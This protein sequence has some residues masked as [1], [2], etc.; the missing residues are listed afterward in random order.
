MEQLYIAI[1]T[2]IYL[3]IAACPNMYGMLEDKED[4]RNVLGCFSDPF[5]VS[6]EDFQRRFGDQLSSILYSFIVTAKNELPADSLGSFIDHNRVKI[7]L[8]TSEVQES[9]S[10]LDLQYLL[11]FLQ[12]NAMELSEYLGMDKSSL[13][14]VTS[15]LLEVRNALAHGLYQTESYENRSD[16]IAKFFRRAI[17]FVKQIILKVESKVY[18]IM[19]VLILNY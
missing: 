16:M 12:R 10:L 17:V 5:L 19:C 15:D 13:L 6:L 9:A 8:S 7:D 11:G 1:N 2:T 3:N 4:S 18:H 14:G